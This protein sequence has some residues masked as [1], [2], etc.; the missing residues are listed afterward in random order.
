[1]RIANFLQVN[2]EQTVWWSQSYF[3]WLDNNRLP[4]L[5]RPQLPEVDET[6][7]MDDFEEGNQDRADGNNLVELSIDFPGQE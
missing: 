1:M 7:D 2:Q 4:S 6:T 3:A 5:V